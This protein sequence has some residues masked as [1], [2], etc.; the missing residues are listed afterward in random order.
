MEKTLQSIRDRLYLLIS[1]NTVREDTIASSLSKRKSRLTLNC[2][3]D[4][5]KV[6]K[7]LRL[8]ASQTIPTTA[9]CKAQLRKKG[10]TLT[11]TLSDQTRVAEENPLVK[12][13]EIPFSAAYGENTYSIN[14][15]DSG[16]T[17]D[18]LRNEE[19]VETEC[20]TIAFALGKLQKHLLV[21]LSYT[22]ELEEGASEEIQNEIDID[23]MKA[24]AAFMA[25]SP[26]VNEEAKRHLTIF[27][28]LLTNRE[29]EPE[30][31]EETLEKERV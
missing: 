3:L 8:C 29:F 19:I 18:V 21:D 17:F 28:E 30:E 25:N 16:T 15:P 10:S 6:A 13:L 14:S 22:E 4:V 12:P 7:Y 5:D 26:V 1:K 27:V 20:P 23:F 24:V 9:T 31:S 11:L 2:N